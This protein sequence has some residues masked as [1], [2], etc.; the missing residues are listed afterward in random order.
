MSP[1]VPYSSS[2][3]P[4]NGFG[5]Q[6]QVTDLTLAP[7]AEEFAGYH[8]DSYGDDYEIPMQGPL[9]ERHVGGNRHRHTDLNEGSDTKTTRAEAWRLAVDSTT[10]TFDEADGDSALSGRGIS[11][12]PPRS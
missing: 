9:T 1:F 7:S 2:V 11:T 8:N 12:Q 10:T 5:Q 6:W 3:S 4:A